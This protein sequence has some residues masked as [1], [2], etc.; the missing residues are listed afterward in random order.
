MIAIVPTIFESSQET[1]FWTHGEG[2]HHIDRQLS[3]VVGSERFGSILILT[4][5]PD[6][7]NQEGTTP[8]ATANPPHPINSDAWFEWV[9]TCVAPYCAGQDETAVYLDFRNPDV[10]IESIQK[11]TQLHDDKKFELVSAVIFD[12]DHPCQWKNFFKT[13]DAGIVHMLDR[14][15]SSVTIRSKAEDFGFGELAAFEA[16]KSISPSEIVAESCGVFHADLAEIGVEKDLSVF[17]RVTTDGNGNVQFSFSEAPKDGQLHLMV[18]AF[19]NNDE[20]DKQ[21]T[22]QAMVDEHGVAAIPLGSKYDFATYALLESVQCG[23]YELQEPVAPPMDLW[24]VALDGSATAA[25]ST[26]LIIGR[27]D[28]PPVVLQEYA[29]LVTSLSKLPQV[30]QLMDASHSGTIMI[31]ATSLTISS[32]HDAVFAS[33]VLCQLEADCAI[34]GTTI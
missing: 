11:A 2:R 16:L 22:F 14:D 25:G 23:P 21:P 5:D 18:Q 13:L 34:S 7:W 31:E 17:H 4:S 1:D 20:E 26:E 9:S 15:S 24:G 33:A 28:F 27:Q 10:N 29:L 30:N 32:D 3:A 8:V 12:D 19:C 6:T